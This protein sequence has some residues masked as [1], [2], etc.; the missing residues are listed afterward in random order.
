MRC[1]WLRNVQSG[2]CNKIQKPLEINLRAF[3]EREGFEHLM[4]FLTFLDTLK[5]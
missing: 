3:V 2:D 4:P 5:M 1:Q